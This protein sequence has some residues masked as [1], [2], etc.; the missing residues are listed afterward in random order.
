MTKNKL[1]FRTTNG[2]IKVTRGT[3]SVTIEQE[4]ILFGIKEQ[5]KTVVTRLEDG[6]YHYAFGTDKQL[7]ETLKNS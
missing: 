2:K 4:R 3:N 6:A 7:I 5:I 1:E